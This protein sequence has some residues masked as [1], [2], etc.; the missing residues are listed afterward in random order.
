[1]SELNHE[2]EGKKSYANVTF[3]AFWVFSA[4]TTFLFGVTYLTPLWKGIVSIVPIG[5]D[6]TS[7][8]SSILGGLSALMMLDVAY[9][10]WQH[11]ERF[12]S[13]SIEQVDWAR[14]AGTISFVVSLTYS[15]TVLVST[16]F[17]QLIPPTLLV[18]IEWYGMFSIIG[19]SIIHLVAYQRWLAADPLLAEH[20]ARTVIAAQ[21]NSE[22]I[23]Y[24]KGVARKGLLNASKSA[25]QQSEQLADQLAEEWAVHI[26]QIAPRLGVA[27]KN[28]GDQFGTGR[29]QPSLNGHGEHS[30]S[31]NGDG[32]AE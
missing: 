15:G 12:C 13:T 24:Q 20:I 4:V 31:V 18:G 5:T 32:P 27:N 2:K 1:M 10:R 25:Q 11:I 19:V 6:A 22:R 9:L 23:A 16:A 21:M 29:F 26:T 30:P 8:F 7:F 28:G 3:L 14:M 17:H